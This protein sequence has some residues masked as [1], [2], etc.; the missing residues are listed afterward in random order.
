MRHPCDTVNHRRF[1]SKCA[2]VSQLFPSDV[3]Y[4]STQVWRVANLKQA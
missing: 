1:A 2:L 3:S 4:R